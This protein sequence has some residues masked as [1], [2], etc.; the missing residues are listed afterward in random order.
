MTHRRGAPHSHSR[1]KRLAFVVFS[2]L[3][4]LFAVSSCGG[5]VAEVD[6]VA[7]PIINSLEVRRQDHGADT[8][9]TQA[10]LPAVLDYVS[11]PFRSAAALYFTWQFNGDHLP[12]PKY[13][14]IDSTDWPLPTLSTK[15]FYDSYALTN[16]DTSYSFGIY[17]VNY[18]TGQDTSS[19]TGSGGSNSD[20]LGVSN[21]LLSTP[22]QVPTAPDQRYTFIFTVNISMASLP[23][24]HGCGWDFTN[25]FSHFIVHELG[26]QRA[27][28]SHPEDYPQ[29]HAGHLPGGQDDVMHIFPSNAELNYSTPQFDV[30]DS[31]QCTIPRSCQ[32]VLCQWRS[33]RN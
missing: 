6:L 27:G 18:Q 2:W 25:L 12:I 8:I 1:Y 23:S 9:Y 16:R 14:P 29:Y 5:G 17:F 11:A 33:I 7:P 15:T 4:G 10:K 30:E 22:N 26:H 31:L 20:I 3:A 32:A 19:C 24:P 28:L 21:G 13:F